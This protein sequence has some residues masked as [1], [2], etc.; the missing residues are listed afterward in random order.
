MQEL[1]QTLTSNSEVEW[2]FLLPI[3]WSEYKK[4]HTIL[5]I[6]GEV[7]NEF[8]SILLQMSSYGSPRYHKYNRI[9]SITI[10]LPK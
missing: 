10:I 5:P 1:S 2:N 4:I 8:E 7:K 3:V 9:S 6:T